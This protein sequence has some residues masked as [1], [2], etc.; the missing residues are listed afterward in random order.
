MPELP[1]VEVVKKSLNR[2]IKTLTIKKVIIKTKK[3][4]YLINKINLT[5]LQGKKIINI[6]RRSKYLIFYFDQKIL[7]LVHLGMTGKF[8]IKEKNKLKKTSFH[9]TIYKNTS[10][11]NHIIFIL[12]KNKQLIYNDVRKFGF[13]KTVNSKKLSK[14]LHLKFLGPEPL[15]NNFNLNYFKERILKRKRKIKDLLMDQKFVSGLGN[16]YV[17]EVLYFSKVN[18]SKN[19]FKI[20]LH[21]VKNII[22]FTKIVLKKSIKEGGSS[23]KNFENSDGKVG[24]YQQK[25]KVYNRAN[26]SCKRVKC[27]SFIRRVIISN[28]STFFCPDCQK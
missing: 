20:S 22:K 5:K 15:S 16:I 14:N 1:E 11:H 13:I 10:K 7:L 25:F 23:I 19:I 2:N 6:K 18:P 21:E 24:K 12:N 3:L 8:L 9:D 26:Q 28:R 17:N 27:K 4:R